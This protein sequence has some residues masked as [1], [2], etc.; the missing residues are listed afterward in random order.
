[1]GLGYEAAKHFVRLG[2][3]KVI[4]A[5][6]SLKKGQKAAESIENEEHRH[7]VVEVWELDLGSY[8]SVKAFAKRVDGLKRIDAVVENAGMCTMTFYHET[9]PY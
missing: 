5:C 6:R 2:S 4:L 8:E 7:G 3:K 1:M 9:R